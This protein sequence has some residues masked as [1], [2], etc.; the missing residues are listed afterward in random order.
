MERGKP[1]ERTTELGRGAVLEGG[2]RRG[3][4]KPSP[5]RR[6][7][8]PDDLTR[9]AVYERDG[10]ACVCCGQSIIGRLHSVGHRKRR[11]QGG[12]NETSN[13]LTFLGDGSG[14]FD[15]DHHRRIDMRRDPQDEKRGLTVRSWLDPA[16]IR[17]LVTTRH[18]EQ[19]LVFLTDD[20]A[21]SSAPPEVAA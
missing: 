11:S 14:R 1:L 20:A 6:D 4:G 7:T 5:R 16:E 17:V 15:D 8:G 10:Y 9:K 21:Y 12:S 2:T 3:A 18:G 19:A 13:L